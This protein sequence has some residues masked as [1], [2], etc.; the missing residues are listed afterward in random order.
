[1]TTFDYAHVYET[2]YRPARR[3]RRAA[4]RVLWVGLLILRPRLAL[5][6][7]AERRSTVGW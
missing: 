1:M 5:E 2:Q 3:L 7:L 6:I 4:A